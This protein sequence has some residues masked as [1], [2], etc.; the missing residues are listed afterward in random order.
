MEPS[1]PLEGTNPVYTVTSDLWLPELLED[2]SLLSRTI[3]L[4]AGFITAVLGNYPRE[5]FRLESDQKKQHYENIRGEE[6]SVA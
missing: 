2:K 5:L 3:Q 1:E 4:A 6:K